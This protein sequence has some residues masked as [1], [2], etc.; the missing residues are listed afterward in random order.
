MLFAFAIPLAAF[1]AAYHLVARSNAFQEEWLRVAAAVPLALASSGLVLL[2][3]S[4]A[5]GSISFAAKSITLLLFAFLAALLMKKEVTPLKNDWKAF[6]VVAAGALLFLAINHYGYLF[7]EDGS[8][9]SILNVWGDG[10]FHYGVINSFALADNFPPEYPMLAGQEMGY[11]FLNDFYSAFLVTE[12]IGLRESIII[13][14]ALLGFSLL[15][16]CYLFTKRVTGSQ[17]AALLVLLLFFVN[18]NAGL[19]QFNGA[20]DKD[21]S[22]LEDNGLWFMNLTYALFLPQRSL[23]LGY[24]LFFLALILI[25]RG[26]KGN[27]FLAGTA[28]GLMPLAHGHSCI[29]LAVVGGWMLLKKKGKQFFFAPAA[30]LAA[31]QLAWVLSQAASVF[32]GFR[33]WWLELLREMSV[34]GV[35][36]FWAANWWV[37]GLVGAGALFTE[38]KLRRFAVPFIALFVLANVFRFQPWDWDNI[39]ILSYAFYGFAVLASITLVKLASRGGW[40]KAVAALAVLLAVGSGVLTFAWMLGGQNAHYAVFDESDLGFAEWVKTTPKDAV[41]LTGSSPQSV[42]SALGGR[43]SYLG[44]TGWVWSHGLDYAEREATQKRVY[45]T[46]NCALAKENGINFVV[47]GNRESHLEVNESVFASWEKVFD[48]GRQRVYQC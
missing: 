15:A 42:P 18:G 10:P 5:A 47:V 36:A 26:G 2:A 8:Y 3:F 31:P 11:P 44:F 34:A 40:R 46:G 23:L 16:L 17:A 30:L 32:S 33:F 38:K 6:A 22:H 43:A 1:L 21:Y 9:N 27:L 24:A 45:A 14:N 35:L 41:F 7:Y 19:F 29:A 48:N 28:A 13:P 37:V 20:L 4:W 12:G 39:K 25:E